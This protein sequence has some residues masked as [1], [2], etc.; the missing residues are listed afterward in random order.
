VSLP[1][2]VRSEDRRFAGSV[3]GARTGIRFHLTVGLDPKIRSVRQAVPRPV[4]PLVSHRWRR[5]FG[6]SR[7]ALPG[8]RPVDPADGGIAFAFLSNDRLASNRSSQHDDLEDRADSYRH[9]DLV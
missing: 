6:R 8:E 4:L 3:T 7:S 9:L 2:I 1:L 5:S